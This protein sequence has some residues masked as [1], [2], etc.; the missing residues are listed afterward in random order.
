MFKSLASLALL[1]VGA[2]AFAPN[3]GFNARPTTN[4]F[5]VEA[6][7]ESIVAEQLGVDPNTVVPAASFTADL[8]ADSLDVVELSMAIGEAFN[9]KIPEEEAA[10]MTTVQDIVDYIHNDSKAGA[11]RMQ[12]A[13]KDLEK[14]I[15]LQKKP[16]NVSNERKDREAFMQTKLKDLEEKDFLE[17]TPETW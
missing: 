16:D 3:P 7:V 10:K 1:I 12:N 2:A 6:K 17:N 13:V 8:G 5:S 9:I 14:L 15:S 4:L 11:E